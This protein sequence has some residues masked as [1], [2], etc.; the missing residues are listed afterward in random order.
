MSC[1]TSTLN[2]FTCHVMKDQ[3]DIEMTKMTLLYTSIFFSK[4]IKP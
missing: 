3:I 1:R 2:F 4:F